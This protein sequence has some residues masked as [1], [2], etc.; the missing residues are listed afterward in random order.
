MDNKYEVL[1]TMPIASWPFPRV[2]VCWL[3]ERT[4]SYADIVIPSMMDIMA[5]GPLVLQ[6]PYTRT[7]VARN[8]AGI[9]LLKSNFTHLLMLDIDHKHPMDIIQR[10]SKWVID[11]P[12]KYQVVGGL[13]FRRSEPHDPCAYKMDGDGRMYAIEWDENSKL[14]EVDRLGTGSILISREVFEKLELPWF[15]NIYDKVWDDAWPGEDIGF[16]RKCKDAGIS[17][18]CDVTVTSPHITPAGIDEKSWRKW[19]EKH[20]DVLSKQTLNL[21]EVRDNQ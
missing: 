3:L 2:M 6:M 15:Y 11:D 12:K 20:P 16:S 5:Q 9:E 7:D 8:K 14:I 4:I 18:W 13:N 19:L 17:M 10:L 1:K 21:N